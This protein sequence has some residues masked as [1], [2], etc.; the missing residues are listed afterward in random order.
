MSSAPAV[1]GKVI[2]KYVYQYVILM[3]TFFTPFKTHFS[4]ALN[5]SKMVICN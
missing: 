3:V 2:C 1:P 4:S 5:V